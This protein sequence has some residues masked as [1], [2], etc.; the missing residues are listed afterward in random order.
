MT[1][2]TAP[3]VWFITGASRGLGRAFAEAALAE[4]DRVI[5]TARDVSA[6]DDLVAE[7]EGSLVTLS[8]DVTDRTAVIATVGKAAATFGRLDIVV[9]NAGQLLFGMLEE[10]T[11]KQVRDHFDTNVFGALWVSQ[12]VI[13]HLRAQGSGHI[14]QVTS[15]GSTGGF[16]S[17]GVYGAGKAALDALSEALA[18]EVESFGITVTILQPG[19]FATDLFTRGTTAS[20]PN[21]A[22]AALRAELA[23]LWAESNDPDPREAAPVVLEVTRMAEPP[24]RLILGSR[25][26]DLVVQDLLTRVGEH[27]RWEELS[28]RAGTT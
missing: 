24:K 28:G 19:S 1:A 27:R 21:E 9:N 17:V 10:S 20:E 12:A 13:P 5:G 25:S 22:Y 18:M 2:N 6:L 14:L 16:A 26:Y 11:E 3:R 8:L 23:E 4:G 7:Y 15:M